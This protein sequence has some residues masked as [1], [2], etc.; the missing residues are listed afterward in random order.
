LRWM[1]ERGLGGVKKLVGGVV[2]NAFT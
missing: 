2:K 1:E